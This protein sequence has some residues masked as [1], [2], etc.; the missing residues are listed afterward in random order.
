MSAERE[1]L[2]ALPPPNESRYKSPGRPRKSPAPKTTRD[3]LTPDENAE[4]LKRRTQAFRWPKGQTG[5]P[6]G[7]NRFYMQSRL[8]ARRAAPQ[9]TR[10]LIA[11]ALDENEDSR[12][13]S[14]AAVAI[15]DRAGVRP[16]DFDPNAEKQPMAF[17][18]RDF[19]P[20]ELDQIE[21]ALKLIVERGQPKKIAPPPED[22]GAEEPE[23]LDGEII[24][25][26][27]DE[28]L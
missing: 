20:G 28:P 23:A 24:P 14:V 10:V 21:A 16:I 6:G 18:P 5:N 2:P 7:V 25:P 13:R 22:A 17:N 3:T 19:D 1:K 26:E 12:V 4:L 11:L 8:L 9:M 15:L 27:S